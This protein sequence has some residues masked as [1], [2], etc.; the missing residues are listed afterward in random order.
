[1]KR[2]CLALVVI[3]LAAGCDDKSPSN[4]SPSPTPTPNPVFTSTLTS[5]NE[6]PPITD[7][8]QTAASQ[9]AVRARDGVRKRELEQVTAGAP[10]DAEAVLHGA[11][12]IAEEAR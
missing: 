7:T 4:P 5:A 11:R 6:V 1:M 8:E 9:L 2:A 3:A 10:L 12:R